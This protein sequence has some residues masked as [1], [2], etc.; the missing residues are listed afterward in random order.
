MT[1]IKKLFQ[2]IYY[3]ITVFLLFYIFLIW[4][5]VFSVAPGPTGAPDLLKLGRTLAIGP[6]DTE[7]AFY[8]SIP[9]VLISLVSIFGGLVI[10]RKTQSKNKFLRRTFLITVGIYLIPFI[11]YLIPFIFYL[12]PKLFASANFLFFYTSRIS[13]W[14]F[15]V[16]LIF[17]FLVYLFLF[18]IFDK[19]W[20]IHLIIYALI[21]I[22]LIVSFTL[23]FKLYMNSGCNNYQDMHC[24]GKL[25]VSK[26][27]VSLCERSLKI[28]ERTSCLYSFISGKMGEKPVGDREIGDVQFCSTLSSTL[29]VKQM[30]SEL[31]I[32]AYCIES[33]V[34]YFQDASD[35][36]V[37]C[38]KIINPKEKE[39]CKKTVDCSEIPVSYDEYDNCVNEAENLLK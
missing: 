38:D 31:S 34:L 26:N 23:P 39:H 11:F 21:I 4:V 30:E 20:W 3:L 36:K 14:L 28:D 8:L 5:S 32:Q 15:P 18:W 29:K 33:A 27:D 37:I 35:R 2:G 17:T 10:Y 19:K 13:I 25:A 22:A 16:F 7:L 24:V 9:L 6:G 12:I 1:S